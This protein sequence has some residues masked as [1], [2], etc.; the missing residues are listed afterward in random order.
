MATVA[1]LVF[2]SEV[3]WR[4]T[5][6]RAPFAASLAPRPSPILSRLDK[7]QGLPPTTAN[8]KPT[9]VAKTP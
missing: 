3:P 7:L 2:F 9:T 5:T 8:G 4:H 1:D 6:A